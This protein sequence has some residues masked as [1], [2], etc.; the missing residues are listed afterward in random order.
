MQGG[1]D[2]RERK[3]EGGEDPPLRAG[4][5][6][7]DRRRRPDSAGRSR[8]RARAVRPEPGDGAH[9]HAGRG[10]RD[11]RLDAGRGRDRLPD[12]AH[13][14]RRV[15]RAHGRGG[16][17]RRL[18]GPAHDQPRLAAVRGRRLR[19]RR[20]LPVARPRPDRDDDAAAVLGAR[21]RH[22]PAA[23][24]HRPRCRPAHGLGD[25]RQRDVH[26]VRPGDTRTRTRSTPRATACAWSSSGARTR[27][28]PA[29]AAPGNRRDQPD[30]HRLPEPARDRGRDLERA[31]DLVQLQRPRRRA[32]GPRVVLHLRA[33]A[34]VHHRPAPARG[35][36]EHDRP[37]RPVDQ[38]ERP[39]GA[40]PAATRR[41]PT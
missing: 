32:A 10:F 38:R 23:V 15:E 4:G 13:A 36:L 41:A 20:P 11:A 34:R 30:H 18:A 28:R 17:R 24:G 22:H 39:R 31:G 29:R 21:L 16:D 27:S 12:R 2:A 14:G 9:R 19:A 8:G 6:R 35:A 40:T 3:A 25:E 1:N 33:H 26:D 5:A 7:H 37:A